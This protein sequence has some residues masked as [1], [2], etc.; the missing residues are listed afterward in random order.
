MTSTKFVEAGADD[1]APEKSEPRR[2]LNEAQVLALIPVSRTTLHRM[3]KAGHFPKGT[4]VSANRRL[5]FA[6]EVASWQ[7]GVD[8][9]NPSRGRGKGRRHTVGSKLGGCTQKQVAF[10]CSGRADTVPALAESPQM[11]KPKTME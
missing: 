6:D 2:M 3:T 8:E 10:D 9:F 5:W 1:G 7:N 11:T 4:Y